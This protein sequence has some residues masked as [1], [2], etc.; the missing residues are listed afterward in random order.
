[1]AQPTDQFHDPTLALLVNL[2]ADRPAVVDL[3]KEAEVLPEEAETL[4]DTAFADTQ[5]RAFPI[6]SKEHAIMSR[7]YADNTLNVPAYVMGAIKEAC[8]MYGVDEAVFERT[9]QAAAPDD[10]EDYLL[11]EMKRL[12]VRSA[13]Q[14]K[15]AEATLLAGYQKLAFENRA[16]ACSRL[17]EKAAAFGVTL[18]PLMHKLAGFTVSSTAVVKDWLGARKEAAPEAYKGA[19]QKLADGLK[20]LPPEVRD[21]N[22]LVKLAEVIGELDKKAG[23]VKYYD[24]KLPDP[25]QT[26]FNT[27]KVAGHGVDLNGRFVSIAKLAEHDAQ[28]YSDVLGDDVVREASD[29][30]GGIDAQKL[31]MILDTLPR[32]MKVL[33]SSHLRS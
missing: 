23:L 22:S 25:L 18:D 32:D 20:G 5:K 26:V 14:V 24:R 19:F 4:P 7:V 1:M 9:K 15:T 16:L 21:R 30:R 33:L 31:A 13:E 28:F 8:D 29:G 6:H 27:T 10:P 11:P 3:V 17:I 2:V 12:P